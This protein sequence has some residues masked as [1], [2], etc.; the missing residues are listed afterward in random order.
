MIACDSEEINFIDE[1]QCDIIVGDNCDSMNYGKENDNQYDSDNSN[2]M[3]QI[4]IKINNEIELTSIIVNT[5]NQSQGKALNP[6][7]QDNKEQDYLVP[8]QKEGYSPP[9][10]LVGPVFES[11]ESISP[12]SVL[13]I[14]RFNKSVS[15]ISSPKKT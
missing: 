7:L 3:Q 11:P 13:T 12:P 6:S 15:E 14:Q 4:V 8:S 1:N 9:P 10:N 5:H 2:D